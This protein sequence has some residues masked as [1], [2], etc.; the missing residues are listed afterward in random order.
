MSAVASS[1]RRQLGTTLFDA[2]SNACLWHLADIDSD[3]EHAC[4]RR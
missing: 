2:D 4:F 3:A 1:Y